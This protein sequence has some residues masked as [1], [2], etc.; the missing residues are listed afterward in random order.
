M[1]DRAFMHVLHV[2]AFCAFI[3]ARVRVGSKNFVLLSGK[4]RGKNEI[5]SKVVQWRT[6]AVGD[7]RS[8]LLSLMH[9]RLLGV[10]GMRLFV[11]PQV[12]V[13]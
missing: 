6:G 9:Q 5:S 7:V 8:W 10:V 13:T 2:G 3:D 11:S 4:S 12:F 1:R